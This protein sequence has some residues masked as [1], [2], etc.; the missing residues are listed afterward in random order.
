MWLTSQCRAARSTA[1]PWPL[2]ASWPGNRCRAKEIDGEADMLDERLTFENPLTAEAGMIVDRTSQPREVAKLPQD[3]VLVSA[4]NHIELTED[5]FYERFPADRRQAAP[6]V[7]F[8]RY[9]RVGFPDS[10]QAY[11]ESAD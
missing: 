1:R 4:D 5:I 8:D 7:W 11:P 2:S 3:L 9:W 10:M 6:R